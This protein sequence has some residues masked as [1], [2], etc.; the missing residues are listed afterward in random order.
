M[1][2][3]RVCLSTAV[4]AATAL[5]ETAAV[6]AAAPKDVSFTAKYSGT[7]RFLQGEEIGG[8]GAAFVAV[9]DENGTTAGNGIERRTHW[10]GVLHG[11]KGM[12]EATHSY[13]VDTDPDGDKVL[14]KLVTPV[15]PADA[16]AFQITGEAVWGTGKYAGVSGTANWTCQST[17]DYRAYTITCDSQIKYTTP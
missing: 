3:Y 10:F 5:V 8:P 6:A 4:I 15:H 12:V 17:G 2:S 1:R 16:S 13:S 11:A 14:W 7:G 9:F